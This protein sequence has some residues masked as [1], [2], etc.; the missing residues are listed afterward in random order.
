[1]SCLQIYC[2]EGKHLRDDECVE[3]IKDVVGIEYNL[4]MMFVLDNEDDYKTWL[5]FQKNFS[6][7]QLIQLFTL[8]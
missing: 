6:H 4:N 7:I 1:G 2:T 3:I 5:K 8:H